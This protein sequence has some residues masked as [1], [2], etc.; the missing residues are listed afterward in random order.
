LIMVKLVET[1][2]LVKVSGGSF[3]KKSKKKKEVQA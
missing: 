3:S 2:L 1:D